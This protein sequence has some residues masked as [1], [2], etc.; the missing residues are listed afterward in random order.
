MKGII[1]S[2]MALI[3]F[4]LLLAMSLTNTYFFSQTEAN[5]VNKI[6]TDSMSNFE[7][8]VRKDLEKALDV[9][10]RRA[11]VTAINHVSA[12]AVYLEDA[13]RDLS[14]LTLNGT[15]NNTYQPIM[16]NN[17]LTD[18]TR[19]V[20]VKA[21]EVGLD[22]SV[23][24]NS[25]DFSL[26]DAFTI[27]AELSATI[28]LSDVLSASS[29]NRT[30]EVSAT[31]SLEGFEDPVHTINTDARVL[32]TIQKTSSSP[33]VVSYGEGSISSGY[34]HGYA[35]ISPGAAGTDSI[36]VCANAS[37]E[38]LSGF[39]GVVSECSNGCL[40]GVSVPYVAGV[41]GATTSISSGEA[42]YLD[43]DSDR[44]YGMSGFFEMVETGRYNASLAGPTFLD[45]LEGKFINTYGIGKGIES[46]VNLLDISANDLT[47][48][49]NQDVTDYL[50]FDNY[51]YPASTI[52]GVSDGSDDPY[53]PWFKL[54]NGTAENYGLDELLE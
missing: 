45:R 41:S 22:F 50:Y 7:S 21:E 38:N 18:W 2:M 35:V 4:S 36:L 24:F 28:L 5:I 8:T 46:F 11:M 40:S 29:F 47:I 30:E 43:S 51:T 44:V 52:H 15:L 12:N 26:E 34:R 16:E 17:T 31:V 48:K 10:A 49:S 37:E 53:Y 3:F 14:S 9:S 25:L 23:T 1:Y 54:G 33:I 20:E 19:N 39:V 42:L 13:D 6:S 27:R 32:R